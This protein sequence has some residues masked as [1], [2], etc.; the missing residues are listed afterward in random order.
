MR[1]GYE[2]FEHVMLM[3]FNLIRQY[4]ISKRYDPSSVLS[5]KHLRINSMFEL[6][7][8]LSNKRRCVLVTKITSTQ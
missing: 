5:S 2:K 7:N 4:H 8:H 1:I 3:L 6:F